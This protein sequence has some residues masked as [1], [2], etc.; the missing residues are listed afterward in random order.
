LHFRTIWRPSKKDDGG[1]HLPA[2]RQ[3][4]RNR[5]SRRSAPDPPFLRGGRSRRPL[6]IADRTRER[7]QH[8]DPP[9]VVPLRPTGIRHYRR[10][11]S[12]WAA[13]H[14]QFAL[15]NRFGSVAERLADVFALQIGIRVEN[16]ILCHP[17][18]HHPD[19]GGNGNPQ[20]SYARKSVHLGGVHGDSCEGSH[21]SILPD[22]EESSKETSA[23]IQFGFEGCGIQLGLGNNPESERFPYLFAAG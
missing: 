2:Q 3:N 15:A 6:P 12:R 23:R 1:L 14:G 4:A 9:P 8:R 10:G 20:T 17:F 18:T 5:C 21:T 16:L 11:I 7:E 19:D 22:R 13:E